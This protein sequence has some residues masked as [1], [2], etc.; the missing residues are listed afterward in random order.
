MRRL[1]KR[2]LLW[3]YAVWKRIIIACGSERGKISKNICFLELSN[4]FSRTKN[5]FESTGINKPS[6]FESLK[7]YFMCSS[8]M[9]QD[10][11]HINTFSMCR[12]DL[13]FYFQV[14]KQL[15]WN[16]R[17]WRNPLRLAITFLRGKLAQP[18][19]SNRASNRTWSYYWRDRKSVFKSRL[20]GHSSRLE[21]LGIQTWCNTP[22]CCSYYELRLG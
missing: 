5:E 10:V 2:C 15:F 21:R 3:I 13:F 19:D 16:T 18:T 22:W 20:S 12:L 14:W 4:K 8:N 6:V 17:A 1:I 7:F 9:L 11:P